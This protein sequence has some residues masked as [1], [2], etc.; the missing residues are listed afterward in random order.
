MIASHDS[1]TQVVN[2]RPGINSLVTGVHHVEVIDMY[3]NGDSEH[4]PHVRA[5]L[6]PKMQST[7]C[8]I[9]IS[10]VHLT[11]SRTSLT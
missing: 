8:S 2:I 6:P 7:S 3:P 11:P 5:E 4:Q 1:L 9:A 10:F